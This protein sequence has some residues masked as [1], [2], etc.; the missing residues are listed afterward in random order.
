MITEINLPIELEYISG[1][2]LGK[3]RSQK[4]NNCST[5]YKLRNVHYTESLHYVEQN[6][7]NH[8]NYK[9]Y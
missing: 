6:N 8:L 5:R 1:S 3:S 9:C 2:F 7:F 4:Q